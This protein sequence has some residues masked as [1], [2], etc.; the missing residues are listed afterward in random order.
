MQGNKKGYEGRKGKRVPRKVFV[1]R[2]MKRKMMLMVG[3]VG[4]GSY[5]SYTYRKGSKSVKLEKSGDV[6]GICAFPRASTEKFGT[7]CSCIVIQ[8]IPP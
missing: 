6:F 8:V 1:K 5:S 4:R 7:I 2:K 3:E